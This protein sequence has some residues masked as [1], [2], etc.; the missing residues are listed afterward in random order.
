MKKIKFDEIVAARANE[1]VQKKIFEFKTDIKKAC[2]ELV[3]NTFQG[4]NLS[5]RLPDIYREVLNVMVSDNIRIGWPSTLWDVEKEKVASELLAIMDEM[6]KAM[7][8]ADRAEPG[9][10]VPCNT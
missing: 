10:N 5:E 8:A 3:N 4:Y 9:E 1:R 7:L 6:Q 2:G